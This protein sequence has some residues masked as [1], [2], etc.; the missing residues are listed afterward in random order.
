MIK[1]NV[2]YNILFCLLFIILCMCQTKAN[3]AEDGGVPA[4]SYI[5]EKNMIGGLYSLRFPADTNER[6][7]L[8]IVMTA[9]EQACVS[10]YHSDLT[11]QDNINSIHISLNNT[12]PGDYEV[13]S[14]ETH[15]SIADFDASEK[16]LAL[17]SYI[18][19]HEVDE[20]VEDHFSPF[21]GKVLIS[22]VS[23]T[24]ENWVDLRDNNKIM[25][26]KLEAEFPRDYIKEKECDVAGDFETG[27]ITSEECICVRND[28]SQFTCIPEYYNQNCC[29]DIDAMTQHYEFEANVI[30]CGW[31][32]SSP[33]ET[34]DVKCGPFIEYEETGE[35]L[36][37]DDCRPCET[38]DQPGLLLLVRDPNT[39]ELL[40][41]NG[42]SIT[43]KYENDNVND[44]VMVFGGSSYQNV[45]YN[46]WGYISEGDASINIIMEDGRTSIYSFQN[47]WLRECPGR[48]VAYI[49]IEVPS[50]DSGNE[51]EFVGPSYLNSCDFEK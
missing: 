22:G 28:G 6:S 11:Q 39:G 9:G 38:L 8:N 20:E 10:T 44:T 3:T 37:I 42:V 48:N 1:R 25:Y 26:V 13:V 14:P 24:E 43:I 36:D 50:I 45:E 51:I 40:Q 34:F 7:G 27:E 47:K 17:V 31:L 41:Q 49:V 32:C 18:I 21:Q 19:G 46:F 4:S 5:T 16:Q 23:A 33:V 12:L 15:P 30:P 29:V 35:W 2:N